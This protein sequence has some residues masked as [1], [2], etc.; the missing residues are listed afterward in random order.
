MVLGSESACSH[1]GPTRRHTAERETHT[2]LFVFGDVRSSRYYP[3]ARS[4]FPNPTSAL[5]LSSFSTVDL[6]LKR[7]KKC[8]FSFD[9]QTENFSTRLKPR[10]SFSDSEMFPVCQERA[11]T[12]ERAHSRAP[13]APQA[14]PG[15]AASFNDTLRLCYTDSFLLKLQHL[16]LRLL[17]LYVFLPLCGPTTSTSDSLMCD[18]SA[19]CVSEGPK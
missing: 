11:R 6:K 3:Y 14:V 17:Q 5:T 13:R 10:E 9:E 12:F 1:F 2:D 7:P 16:L 4:L 15:R 8:L 18:S 19:A